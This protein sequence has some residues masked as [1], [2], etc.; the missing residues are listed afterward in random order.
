MT[1][2]NTFQD[3]LRALDE[4]PEWR[5]ALREKI[6]TEELLQLPAVVFK[7]SESFDQRLED[8]SSQITGLSGSVDARFEEM[9][10]QIAKLAESVDARFAQVDARFEEMAAQI[11]KLAESVD[12]RF[13]QVDARFE[14]MAA[15]IAK[16]A[17]SVDARFAQ[18]DA[19]FEEMAA[20][21]AKLA[22]SVD[23]RFAQVD[24]R[25]EEMAAQIAK[26]AESTNVRFG[27]V[28]ARLDKIQDDI[29]HLKGD[30]LEIKLHRT[31][32]TLLGQRLGLRRAQVMHSGLQETSSR[33]YEPVESSLEVGRIT[34]EQE[35]RINATDLIVYARKNE[36]HRQVWVAVEAS[37][38]V[39]EHDIERVRVTADA[40]ETVFGVE[41]LAVVIGY[42]I[43][44]QDRQRADEA[45]VV[46]LEAPRP[47]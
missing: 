30:S 27:E 5:E 43:G 36:D 13:A 29:G 7:L 4:N 21:I 14:E 37:N 25:F 47:S 24:A 32:R 41:A 20:Q 17:E 39:G 15:Q 6:L 28:F 8:V 2:I 42:S 16:L 18:V 34:E 19:R 45:G 46:Y 11:A 40:L 12:A 23:A 3:L 38:T 31:I 44:Q 35:A 1:E 9:A 22:E 26:L 33:L 10:A